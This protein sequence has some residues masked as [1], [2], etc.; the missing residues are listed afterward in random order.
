MITGALLA[1]DQFPGDFLLAAAISSTGILLSFVS[2]K[3]PTIIETLKDGS[4]KSLN[5]DA[6]ADVANSSS[7]ELRR[8]L[9]KRLSRDEVAT[10]WQDIFSE[11]L[12]DAAPGKALGACVDE[13]FLRAREKAVLP[14]LMESLVENFPDRFQKGQE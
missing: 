6:R 9:K 2:T 13:L 8:F 10:V 1:W 7:K 4:F 11:R 14:T 5:N 12:D 3:V